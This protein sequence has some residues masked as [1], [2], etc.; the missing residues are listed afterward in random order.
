LSQ[1]H[2]PATP[3]TPPPTTE[4]A[5]PPASMPPDRENLRRTRP[6]EAGIGVPLSGSTLTVASQTTAQWAPGS[7]N[8]PQPPDWMGVSLPL[9]GSRK[10]DRDSTGSPVLVSDGRLPSTRLPTQDPKTLA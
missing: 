5:G 8:G 3:R 1:A 2:R 6:P 10:N 7:Q 4:R 9:D